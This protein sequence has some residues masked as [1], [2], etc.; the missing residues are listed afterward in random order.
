MKK[1]SIV[2]AALMLVAMVLTACAPKAPVATEAPKAEVKPTEAPKKLKVCLVTDSGGL[3]DKSFN[4]ASYLGVQNGEK[5]FGVE[6]KVLQSK[7]GDDFQPNLNACK[8]E[9]ADLI[10]CVGFMMTDACKAAATANPTIKYAGI[11]MG[12]FN[13][14]NFR[15]VTALME[16]STFLAGYLS[17]GMSTTGKL[18]WYVGIMG[19]PVQSFGDGFYYGVQEYNKVKG[20]TVE[21]LGY[22]ALEPGKA[23][24]TGSWIDAAAGKAVSTS[25]MDEG[26]DII[27]PVCGGVGAATAALMQERKLGY[28]WGVDQDWTLTYPQYIDQI[29]GSVTKRI[30]VHVYDAIKRLSTNTWEGGDFVLTLENEGTQLTYNSKVAVPDALKAEVAELAKKI[31]SGE[32]KIPAPVAI[33]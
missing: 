3:G 24:Q 12:G 15:G 31:I 21:V 28:I 5:D 6:G 17:A 33:Q 13:L 2:L 23:T 27:L 14:P 8:D 30:D 16:Q 10:I 1:L 9:G 26:A 18:G 25:L 32:I 4:D 11:D 20:K 7:T 19:P 29:I 22:N